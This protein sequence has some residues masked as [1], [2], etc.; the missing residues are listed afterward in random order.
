M[1]PSN[2]GLSFELAA[3]Q[4]LLA[5][6]MRDTGRLETASALM[7]E[8]EPVLRIADTPQRVTEASSAEHLDFLLD[9]VDL[10]VRKQDR[11]GAS[12]ALS[13]LLEVVSTR[14]QQVAASSEEE[15]RLARFRYLWW[16][17]QGEDPA[18]R[19]PALKGAG[20]G[21]SGQ[22]RRC[23]DAVRHAMLAIVAG[24]RAEAVRQADYLASR[25]YRD[26][27]YLLFCRQHGLCAQ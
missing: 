23:N 17:L 13:E 15:D 27:G 2:K 1:D 18:Q 6:L 5:A 19:H 14:L 8:A 7:R 4:R 25:A 22:Y 20:G 12:R 16:E 9:E 11:A 24:D 10:L 3:N 21:V 26:P